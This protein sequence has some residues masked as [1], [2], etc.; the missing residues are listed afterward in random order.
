MNVYSHQNKI[1]NPFFK[2]TT[3]SGIAKLLSSETQKHINQLSNLT[4]STAQVLKA[5]IMKNLS[6]ENHKINNLLSHENSI[7]K[8]IGNCSINNFEQHYSK[9][10]SS[11]FTNQISD[12][13]NPNKANKSSFIH[14][15]KLLVYIK[16]P[17][18]KIQIKINPSKHSSKL[19][20]KVIAYAANTNPG[21]IRFFKK[22]YK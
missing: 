21:I 4:L 11:Y 22:D 8:G 2:P 17:S 5:N 13:E 6:L 19:T 1:S 3:N 16:K 12:L 14:E 18:N 9:K 7:L 10:N 15:L 20:G